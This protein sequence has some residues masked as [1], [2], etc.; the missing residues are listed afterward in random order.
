MR[1]SAFEEFGALEYLKKGVDLTLCEREDIPGG[2]PG[3]W[4]TPVIRDNAWGKLD[5]EERLFA[6]R[7]A[8]NWYDT[9]L[10]EDQSEAVNYLFM[11]E[12]VHHGL[13]CGDVRGACK[14]AIPLGN[15][16]RD[17]LLFR[18]CLELH[19]QV[20]AVIDEK[21]VEEAKREKD[22][23]VAVLFSILGSVL[24]DLGE[25]RE[26][27]DFY[28]QALAID[29]DVFGD[30][31]PNVARDYNNLGLAWDELGEAK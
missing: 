8:S 25:S 5:E 6:H 7:Q 27:I 31:H 24:Q 16:L 17:L 12:A 29:Q 2:E 15:R 9:V 11:E 14:H 20:A 3:Y 19:S 13:Q 10:T 28:N 1:Q 18:E 4:L 23:N 26:A 30:Q 22:G 21:V